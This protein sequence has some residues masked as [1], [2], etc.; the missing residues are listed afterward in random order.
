MDKA[1][2]SLSFL[3]PHPSRSKIMRNSAVASLA[4]ISVLSIGASL[5]AHAS[6]HWP[7]TSRL[8]D[9]SRRLARATGCSLISNEIDRRA[10]SQRMD[11]NR[12]YDGAHANHQWNQDRD[13]MNLRDRSTTNIPPTRV[14]PQ[15][16]TTRQSPVALFS[17]G[18]SCRRG[19]LSFSNRNDDSCPSPNVLAAVIPLV[20]V[21]CNRHLQNYLIEPVADKASHRELA[22]LLVA[23]SWRV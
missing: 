11:K 5:S 16:G 21:A 15:S 9:R 8:Q 18:C 14:T 23:W 13:F 20:H 19:T 10:H 2:R 3:K 4:I 12:T 6:R 22:L 7:I 17:G 1:G